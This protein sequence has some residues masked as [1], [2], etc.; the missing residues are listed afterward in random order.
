MTPPGIPGTEAGP[1]SHCAA[2]VWTR[3]PGLQGGPATKMYFSFQN[4]LVF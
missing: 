3:L 2:E 1:V 4:R